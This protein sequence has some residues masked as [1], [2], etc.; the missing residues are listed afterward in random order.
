[1]K[2]FRDVAV[3][4]VGH[5]KFGRHPDKSLM[6][7]FGEAAIKAIKESNIDKKQIQA[8]FL[9]QHVGEVTDGASNVAGFASTEVGIQGV[10]AVRY[11]GACA[12]SAVAFREAYLLVAAGVYDVVLVGGVERLLSAGTALGTK[13][14]A[15]SVDSVYEGN[16]GLTFPGVFGMA[17]VFYSKK[18]GIPLDE[19]R[20]KMA[21]VS[22]KNHKNGAKN[23]LSQFYGKYGDLKPE[24]VVNSRMIAYPLT[25]LDC[26]PMTDGAAACVLAS[27]DIAEKF[28]TKPV[29]VLGVGQSSAGALYRQKDIT[30][31]KARVNSSREAFKQAGVTPEDVNV[32]ELHDCF[33][34]AEIIALE[35][36]GFFEFGTAADATEKGKTQIGSKLPVN[37]SGGL[38]GKGHPVG[39]TG[40]SQIYCIVKQLRNEVEH[41]DLQVHGAKIGMTDTLGGDFTTI[42]NIILGR[43]RRGE[44]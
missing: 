1:M 39:A 28:H 38:I 34:I 40:V 35:A 11:E 9:G 36:M 30:V 25:L 4:G 2:K 42:C 22:V 18:Y 20:V 24:D 41:R 26:C 6:D 16:V 32:V 5:T 43:E 13:A 23:P 3:L 29:Y 14:L 27:A 37:P 8:L 10:P 12:S 21:H 31:P 7:L 44:A 19:L 17:A 33:T 15:T